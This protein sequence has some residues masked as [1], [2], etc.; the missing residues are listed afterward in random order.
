MTFH[1]VI[2][3][4]EWCYRGDFSCDDY[5]K[6]E[7]F[8]QYLDDVTKLQ[9]SLFKNIRYKMTVPKHGIF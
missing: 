8:L 9:R 2:I 1:F 5:K 4:K 7:G 6:L 3:G